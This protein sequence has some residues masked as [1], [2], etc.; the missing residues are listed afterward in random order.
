MDRQTPSRPPLPQLGLQSPTPPAP[1]HTLP[2]PAP[3]TPSPSPS[4]SGSERGRSPP[5]S[6]ESVCLCGH[7]ALGRPGRFR[8]EQECPS[9]LASALSSARLC[10]P[11]ATGNL[12]PRVTGPQ[13][14]LGAD[15]WPNTAAQGSPRGRPR[16][17]CGAPHPHR[18][19][20][21]PVCLCLFSVPVWSSGRVPGRVA[22]LAWVPVAAAAPHPSRRC[23]ARAG[24]GSPGPHAALCPGLP[25]GDPELPEGAREHRL[26]PDRP[27]PR[28]HGSSHCPPQPS[29]PAAPH[30]QGP[31]DRQ[32]RPARGAEKSRPGVTWPP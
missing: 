21:L 29:S 14:A 8:M 3:G 26:H 7:H 2:Q 13:P 15:A 12:G 10:I 24:R 25:A 17:T 31:G 5:S 9:L 19:G 1:P 20:F 28:L 27:G 6:L 23:R 11:P 4:R 22:P 16:W 30:P 18:A 32:G